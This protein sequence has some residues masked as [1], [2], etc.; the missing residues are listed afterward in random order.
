MSPLQNLKAH[1]NSV[2]IE[3]ALRHV[4]KRDEAPAPGDP[5]VYV[6]EQGETFITTDRIVKTISPPSF[7]IPADSEVFPDGK[8]PDYKFLMHHFKQEGRLSEH[9]LTYI[10]QESAAIFEQEPNMLKVPCPATVVGDIHG[11]Y[12]DLC[13]MLNMCGD[14]A[15]TQY[16]FLGDYVDRGDYSMECLILL[17]AMKIN[18]PKS[19]SVPSSTR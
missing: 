13:K 12:Y 2:K 14:P 16:L 8:N 1:E 5:T 10:L 4:K 9:Q 15:K 11:Q 18:F 6:D 7:R 17:L 3:N 19:A